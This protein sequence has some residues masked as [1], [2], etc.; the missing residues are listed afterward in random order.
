[1]EIAQDESDL[2]AKIAETRKDNSLLAVFVDVSDPDS[3]RKFEFALQSK[4]GVALAMELSR[5]IHFI[6]GVPLALNRELLQSPYFSFYLE[7]RPFGFREAVG[8]YENSFI[9]LSE[10]QAD[11][12]F[13]STKD[14]ISQ[15]FEPVKKYLLSKGLSAEWTMRFASVY[16][17]AMENLFPSRFDLGFSFENGVVRMV[18]TAPGNLERD[19]LKAESLL[20]MGVSLSLSQR[21]LVIFIPCFSKAE[22]AKEAFR[23]I[24][25][26]K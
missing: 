21:K 9:P 6:S 26:E 12:F 4:M 17:E 5:S 16:L 18:L 14:A 1:L 19:R 25:L 13:S 11:S 2:C 7:R 3:L 20:S 23:F 22:Q 10:I 8:F 15:S 24:K